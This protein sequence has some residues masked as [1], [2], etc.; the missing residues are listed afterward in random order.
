MLSREDYMMIREKSSE[1]VYIKDIAQQLGVHPKTVS[2]ALARGG[3]AP[4]R[5][6]GVRVGKLEPYKA[7]VDALLADDIWNAAVILRRIQ[8]AGYAGG[9]TILRDY[10][11]PKRE[12]RPTGVVRYETA[13]GAQMQH[14]WG[15]CRLMLGGQQT[16]A[17]IAVNVLGHG[18]A[19]HALAMPC[20]DAEHTYEAII[21]AFEYFGGACAT[22]LV[23][24]QKAAVLDWRD[25]RPRFHPRFRELGKHYGFVPKACRPRRAQTKGKVERMVRYVKENALAGWP[26]FDSL[27]E[28]NAHLRHWCDT[29]ANTRTHGGLKQSVAER[30]QAEKPHLQALPGPRYDTAYHGLRQVSL[31]AYI[32][33]NGCRY[34]V[35]G[36]LAGEAVTVQAS[37]EGWLQVHHDGHSGPVATHRLAEQP[38]A[39]VTTQAHHAPLWA[40][41]CVAE[42][43][44][45]DYLPDAR[46]PTTGRSAL[47]VA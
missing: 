40:A 3:E 4:A 8:A 19:V 14:D 13:P 34:S 30:W 21:Q 38:H 7:Q 6:A 2:R 47:E 11:Q 45:A 31:D 37:L 1:G 10:I 33:W 28:L 5:R 18:R 16:T 41:I 9:Y 32:H 39:T 22:V 26:A 29:A 23:D 25:G 12:L 46:Q 27:A 42:R 24:N 15:Q 17:H 20:E 36:Q 35:P 44:L 43:D